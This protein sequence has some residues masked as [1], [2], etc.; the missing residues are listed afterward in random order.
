MSR[1]MPTKEEIERKA[2]EL[3]MAENW[4][5]STITPERHEL[6][7]EGFLKRA[8]ESLM[9]TGSAGEVSYS[10]SRAQM[11][12][13]LGDM[14]SQLNLHI[15]SPGELRELKRKAKILL[16]PGH[17][18]T[19]KKWVKFK[20]AVG[21]ER[22][23]GSKKV[24]VSIVPPKRKRKHVKTVKPQRRKKTPKPKSLLQTIQNVSAIKGMAHIEKD[25]GIKTDLHGRILD[26]KAKK[27]IGSLI[28]QGTVFTPKESF[29]KP[30]A[31]AIRSPA[32]VVF[33]KPAKPAK[34]KKRKRQRSHTE[35]SGKTMRALR[36]V[37][38]VKV[39]SFPDDIWKVR[40][41]RRKRR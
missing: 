25:L 35:R 38:G 8:Q 40:K 31:S 28:T 15:L 16:K 1:K 3:Y 33:G 9:S 39:F 22:V 20:G 21:M 18:W 34:K 24:K 23:P 17:I 10:A 41:P 37:N 29:L 4:E 5:I 32:D 11:R 30:T 36:K 2:V 13:Y 12:E 7:E 26:P 19:G 14:A 6:Q 27:T